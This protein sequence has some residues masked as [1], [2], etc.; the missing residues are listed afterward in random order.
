MGG[1]IAT[2]VAAADR[3]STVRLPCLLARREAHEG[4]GSSCCSGIPL[5]PPGRPTQLRAAHL[6]AIRR[7]MLFVQGSRDNFGTPSELDPVLAGFSPARRFT[8]SLV[9]ITR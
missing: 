5:H 8:L 7:P 6:P 3:D 9:A 1:R 4:G 2:Q